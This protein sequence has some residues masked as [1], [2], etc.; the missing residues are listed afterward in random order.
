MQPF[1]RFLEL[2]KELQI[3]ILRDAIETADKQKRAGL[4]T[5]FYSGGLLTSCLI[6]EGPYSLR[7]FW[8]DD[9]DAFRM[10]PFLS[11]IKFCRFFRLLGLEYWHKQVEGLVIDPYFLTIN[12]D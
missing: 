5:M 8:A 11:I 3:Q 4:F 2:P 10:E 7:P 12:G 9:R 1:P 6:L